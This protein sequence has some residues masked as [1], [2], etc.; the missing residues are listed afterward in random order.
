MLN[1][2]N[3][4]AD[5]E[6]F[7]IDGDSLLMELSLEQNLDW[8]YSG[9][10]LH[11][12]YLIERYLHLFV[13]KGGVFQI[14][15]FKDFENMWKLQPCIYLARKIVML[16][17]LENVSYKVLCHFENPC[18][19][20]FLGYIKEFGPSF[21]LL[22]DG[23][24]LT[25][26]ERQG[27]I[28]EES[29]R[30][31]VLH[32]LKVLNLGI[33][34][35]F[36]RGIRFGTSTLD[37]FHVMHSPEFIEWEL[38][39]PDESQAAEEDGFSNNFTVRNVTDNVNCVLRKLNSVSFASDEE[40]QD[41]ESANDCRP[42]LHLITAGVY[43]KSLTSQQNRGLHY[44]IVR[45][46]LLHGVVLTQFPLKYR[47]FS[48]E[49]FD[50]VLKDAT[51]ERQLKES[52]QNLQFVMA[53]VID[54]SF[55]TSGEEILRWSKSGI[56]D[57]WDGRLIYQV[58]LLLL[59]S[60]RSG[61]VF[62]LTDISK[63]KYE[64]LITVV[65]SLLDNEK[66]LNAFPIIQYFEFNE[67]KI[68]N[69]NN[70]ITINSEKSGMSETREL[71]ER[72]DGLIKVECSLLSEYAGEV[73]E[74]T[75]VKKLDRNDPHV[76]ALVVSG[77]DFDERYH[78]H[79]GKPLTDEYERTKTSDRDDQ[80]KYATFM[81]RYGKSLQGEEACEQ[82]VVEKTNKMNKK[83]ESMNT[84]KTVEHKEEKHNEEQV[85]LMSES[86][87]AQKYDDKENYNTTD[88][89]LTKKYKKEEKC[90]KPKKAEEMKKENSKRNEEEKLKKENAS[91][92]SEKK[93]V[94]KYENNE[95][96]DKALKCLDPFLERETSKIIRI[97]VLLS[98]AQILWKKWKEHC[99]TNK[100]NR[101][102]SGA[103]RLFLRI[104][105]LIENHKENLL[106][107]N[108]DSLG[109]YLEALGFKDI[110]LK[111][112]LTTEKF[113]AN[114]EYSL[115]TSSARFQLRN[116][117]PQLERKSQTDP[118]DRV[119]HF[120]P[121]AWQREMLDAVDN[122]QSALIVAP[123]SSGKTFA[124]FYCMKSVLKEDD[125]GV[126]VYV[127]PTK[128]LVNQ[129]AATCC[130]RYCKYFCVICVSYSSAAENHVSF[131]Q[132]FEKQKLNII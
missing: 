58:L 32:Y 5:A 85:S 84:K 22:S 100:D 37:G 35:A 96:Y 34:C 18:D 53:E 14:V 111:T 79:S 50:N 93:K 15:F 125:D 101:D 10:I 59:A 27:L 55:Q 123:T 109:Q 51:M 24:I 86:K 11:L 39:M 67:T 89:D 23:E 52:L 19:S 98:Y 12:V 68:S 107:K 43:L 132:D 38:P 64:S 71:Q 2:M 117:G 105:E 26:P 114:D 102:E 54:T 118:D 9:Q 47:A 72:K 112:N 21:M 122:K 30:I 62:Q 60:K 8:T 92:L 115:R 48:L 74:K 65:S 69:T 3:E 119:K 104:Q 108:K 126:V 95:N 130:V 131:S 128:A 36:T 33:N 1:L 70:E 81:Q 99:Q 61:T 97:D 103:E 88:E 75:S 77:N 120:I 29:L 73:L 20:D 113:D 106:K 6:I 82:I 16:H 17:L 13:C 25:K 31:F 41:I 91:W 49:E 45:V 76:A 94:E 83:D 66:K 40:F 46:L 78:W 80:K 129:V 110:V 28:P 4:F 44:D 56:C 87:H 57:V 124:S 42:M 127:S 116:L 90:K 63:Q 121:E 7:L